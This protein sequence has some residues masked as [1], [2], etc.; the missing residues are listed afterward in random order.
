MIVGTISEA[1]RNLQR[2]MHADLP[3]YGFNGV[4]W[5]PAIKELRR[6]VPFNSLLD[7]GCGKGKLADS[8][9]AA[10]P[11]VE[12]QRYDPAFDS[13]SAAPQP[14]DIVVCTDVLEHIEPDYIDTVLDQIEGLARKVC[15]FSVSTRPAG[16]IMPDGRNAH[17]IV[18]PA[19]WW[20]PKFGTRWRTHTFNVHQFH[21]VFVG[22]AQ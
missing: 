5:A 9:E 22:L 12:I 8:L 19:E 18:Q 7:F 10:L 13:W 2:Q 1:Y 11:T 14:A 6:L 3:D 15:F 16:K 17:L 21:F 20:M 4:Q